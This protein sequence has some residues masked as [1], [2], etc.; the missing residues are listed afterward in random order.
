MVTVVTFPSRADM[1]RWSKG[2]C[3]SCL[4]QAFCLGEQKAAV[5]GGELVKD[6]KSFHPGELC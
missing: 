6:F 2:D 1:G 4:Q 5:S 3:V